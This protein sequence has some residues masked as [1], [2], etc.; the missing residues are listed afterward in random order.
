MP[1]PNKPMGKDANSRFH[2]RNNRNEVFS[3]FTKKAEE[4]AT[5]RSIKEEAAD[6]EGEL[7]K[8]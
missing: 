2:T 1:I 7:P 5:A 3:K 6:S 4:K 8:G